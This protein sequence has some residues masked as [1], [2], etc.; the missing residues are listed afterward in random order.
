[1]AADVLTD[2]DER[3]L[4]DETLVVWLGQFGRTPKINQNDDI[5]RDVPISYGK[6]I[7]DIIA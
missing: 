6:V 7:H 4:L 5:G 2:L 1:M 3:G